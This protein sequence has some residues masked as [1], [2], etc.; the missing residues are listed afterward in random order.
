MA[1]KSQSREAPT[2]PK[3][4]MSPAV[5][6]PREAQYAQHFR[7]Q[8]QQADAPVGFFQQVNGFGVQLYSQASLF[9]PK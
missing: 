1:A 9:R 7:S 4:D 8:V 3:R 5:Q 2:E 6:A